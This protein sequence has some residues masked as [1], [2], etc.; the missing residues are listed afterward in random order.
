MNPVGSAE[1]RFTSGFGPRTNPVTGQYQSLHNGL[2]IAVPTGTP[3]LA[4]AA[5][6]VVVSGYTET[7]GN[8]VKIDHGNQHA[9]AYLHLSERKVSAG[10]EVRQGQVIGLSGSTG[11]STGPHLHFIVYQDSTPIDPKGVVNWALTAA[12]AAPMAGRAAVV[13]AAV[14]VPLLALAWRARA[15]LEAP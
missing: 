15:N 4:A 14:I 1:L 12:T 2:D 5:G 8:W 6:K 13:A 7:N 11:R 9:T 10:Q 3:I